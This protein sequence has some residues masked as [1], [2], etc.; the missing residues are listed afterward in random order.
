MAYYTRYSG[1]PRYVVDA[2]SLIGKRT[3]LPGQTHQ[4]CAKNAP[5]LKSKLSEQ[6]GAGRTIKV[7]TGMVLEMIR[8]GRW[9]MQQHGTRMESLERRRVVLEERMKL[10][11]QEGGRGQ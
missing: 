10:R 4:T 3:F 6:E 9:R 11:A 5:F 2:P 7:L 1:L 8:S